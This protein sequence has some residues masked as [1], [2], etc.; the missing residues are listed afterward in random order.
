MAENSF[1]IRSEEQK[2]STVFSK[3]E[4][5]VKAER[6]FDEGIPVKYMPKILFVVMLC[7]FYIGNSHYAEKTIRK[8]DK[9]NSEV[10]DLR[11]DYT[12]LKADY[13]YA[14]K[15]SEVAKRVENMGIY[16][17]MTPPQK[18]EIDRIEH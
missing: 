2:S 12:T 6:I 14:S 3:F 16:E 7:I 13:M 4:N 9:L 15:Q 18:I 8:M 5:M 17:S 11:A 10:Q 1:K